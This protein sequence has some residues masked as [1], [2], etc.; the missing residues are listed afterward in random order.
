MKGQIEWHF[1]LHSVNSEVHQVVSDFGVPVPIRTV[2]MIFKSC[3]AAAQG[4]ASHPH[5]FPAF[6]PTSLESL[7]LGQITWVLV[8]SGSLGPVFSLARVAGAGSG[9]FAVIFWQRPTSTHQRVQ[10][11][12]QLPSPIDAPRIAHRRSNGLGQVAR[13]RRQRLG[14]AVQISRGLQSP[15]R[16]LCGRFLRPV[17]ALWSC[18]PSALLL[19]S[20]RRR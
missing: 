5:S 19:P 7:A 3:L 9:N 11:R 4:S 6:A 18:S 2:S 17:R 16:R 8:H 10:N 14:S 12:V 1:G 15:V 13:R 20:H